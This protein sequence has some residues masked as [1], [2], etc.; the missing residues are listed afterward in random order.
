M[1][2]EDEDEDGEG[3]FDATMTQEDMEKAKR[4]AAKTREEKLQHDLF[5]LKKLN[6]AFEVYKDAL[7][8]T[9]SNTDVSA[10]CAYDYSKR[11]LSV[12]CVLRSHTA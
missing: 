6:S 7:R 10:R 11:F 12:S 5:V 2:D 3:G 8:E 9:K 1:A 4:I